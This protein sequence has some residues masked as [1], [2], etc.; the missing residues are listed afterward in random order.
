VLRRTS[1]G[2]DTYADE[3]RLLR[4]DRS[5]VWVSLHV[6]MVRDDADVPQYYS[7]QLQDITARK[8][9][10]VELA[11]SALHDSLTGLPNRSLLVTRLAQSLSDSRRNGSGLGLLFLDIDQFKTVNDSFGHSVGDDL[12]RVAAHRIGGAMRADDLVARLG[13]DEF[14]VVCDNASELE[15]EQVAIR[16]LEALSRPWHIGEL[17]MRVKASVG[18]AIANDESTPESLLRDSDTA[19]YRAKERGRGGIVVFD[20][21]LRMKS[22]RRLDTASALHHALDRDELHIEYQPVVDLATGAMVSV[23]ALL[24]WNHPERGPVSPVEF[25][26]IAEETGLIV[27]IG[28]WVLERACRQLVDWHC[29][30]QAQQSSASA[31]SLPSAARLSVAVNISVRQLLAIDVIDVIQNVLT[32]AGLGPDDVC[33]ELTESVFME[34]VD[35]FGAILGRLKALGVR[36]AID[37]FGTGYSS[38]SYLKRFPV[39][40][41]KLDRAFIDGLGTDPHDTALVAAIAAMAGA[42]QLGVTAE[43]VETVQQLAGLRALHVPRAQ[44]FFFARSMSAEGITQLVRSGHRWDVG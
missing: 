11:D 27:P 7:A 25:I 22:Q 17:E 14:V 8:E 9:L 2:A 16:I 28:A 13:G 39:D 43:G 42:L 18:I 5:I 41:V 10:E 21:A 12:L 34:D 19:M 26:P 44:G 35:F 33:L 38:L 24:R 20:V 30:Q 15:V 37:D 3:R 32:G 1:H 23:E 36:L 29:D 31:G 6:V 40:A 4:R